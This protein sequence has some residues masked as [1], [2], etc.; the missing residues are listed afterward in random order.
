V[1]DSKVNF[2]QEGMER[3]EQLLM[4]S[5]VFVG[6]DYGSGKKT[7]L[8]YLARKN[9]IV[10]VTD[11]EIEDEVVLESSR[12]E[13]RIV[14]ELTTTQNGY[15]A[16]RDREEFEDEHKAFLTDGELFYHT[17]IKAYASTAKLARGVKTIFILRRFST[18]PNDRYVRETLKHI[19][20]QRMK[21]ERFCPIFVIYNRNKQ[22]LEEL[23]SILDSSVLSNGKK[24]SNF[25]N[26]G[27]VEFT[28]EKEKWT[29]AL[30]S[31]AH[32]NDIH[33]QN[34]GKSNIID[35][36]YNSTEGDFSKAICNLYLEWVRYRANAAK[37]KIPDSYNFFSNEFHSQ[38]Q[39]IRK[40][41]GEGD[42]GTDCFFHCI[43]KIL[44]NKRMESKDSDAAKRKRYVGKEF[45]KRKNFFYFSLPKVVD[46]I[47][48]LSSYT[49]APINCIKESYPN[50]CQDI[51]DA[52]IIADRIA[53]FTLNQHKLFIYRSN[54]DDSSI[55]SN[56]FH[57]LALG[58]MT[59]NRNV[60][61]PK[62]LHPKGI[63]SGPRPIQFPDKQREIKL[64]SYNRNITCIE[65]F[66]TFSNFYSRGL[67]NNKNE[68]VYLT[69]EEDITEDNSSDEEYMLNQ[70]E[71]EF[72]TTQRRQPSRP[73]PALPAPTVPPPTSTTTSLPKPIQQPPPPLS[74][75][76]DPSPLH[77]KPSAAQ[78]RT[79]LPF[80]PSS[81]PSPPPTL[82]QP[83]LLNS[84][85]RTASKH[86]L[87]EKPQVSAG[88]SKIE[89]NYT[90][91]DDDFL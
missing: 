53:R 64:Y 91:T 29:S 22:H 35:E 52:S 9:G 10:V 32:F 21:R 58:Y 13:G 41:N 74:H 17:I 20:S 8:S 14:D 16:T 34:L 39:Q 81:N 43:G 26:I 82:R 1:A 86:I 89:Q 78:P 27:Q 31:F 67:V 85:F 71:L 12:R 7:T 11:R 56:P 47:L 84:L 42:E 28:V 76:L 50:F 45:D 19:E 44:Y 70:L 72:L 90:Y 60:R 48:T 77:S 2:I 24:L 25:I 73:L 38:T 63:I 62:E 36:L 87:P 33:Y 18:M 55:D 4:N 51:K 23:R 66:N 15:D 79:Q 75:P 88:G 46:R 59:A 30:Q 61:D 5:I 37:F 68:K 65:V 6:G 57:F 69:R 83:S 80:R 3:Y 49:A 54:I 40:V